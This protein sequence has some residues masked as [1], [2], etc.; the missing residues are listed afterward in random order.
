MIDCGLPP[1][2]SGCDVS[3]EATT[4]GLV[5]M[6]EAHSGLIVKGDSTITCSK[7]GEWSGANGFTMCK[8]N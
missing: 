4:C 5:A 8:G 6:Y 1:N 7:N 3:V 2:I